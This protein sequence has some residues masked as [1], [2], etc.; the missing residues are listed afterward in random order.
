MGRDMTFLVRG[1]FADQLSVLLRQLAHRRTGSRHHFS[2]LQA[3][4]K[5]KTGTSDAQRKAPAVGP[6][7]RSSHDGLAH[8]LHTRTPIRRANTCVEQ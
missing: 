8:L 4:D 6:R 1:R 7:W 2:F 5:R 3:S